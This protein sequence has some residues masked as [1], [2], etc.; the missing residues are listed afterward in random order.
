VYW[1]RNLH[2]GENSLQFYV[3]VSLLKCILCVG[4]GFRVWYKNSSSTLNK[5]FLALCW[6]VAWGAF[7]E[8]HYNF[9]Q[10]PSIA[11]IW[12]QITGSWFV[13]AIIF[14]FTLT[15]VQIRINRVI[16]FVIS[17]GCALFFFILWLFPGFLWASIDHFWWGWQPVPQP[18][19]LFL[20]ARLWVVLLIGGSVAL[21]WKYYRA[22]S[23]EVIK[24]QGKTYLLILGILFPVGFVTDILFPM[25]SVIIPEQGNTLF[26]IGCVSLW[27]LVVRNNLFEVPPEYALIP[28]LS[29][30]SDGFLIVNH[31]QEIIYSNQRMSELLDYSPAEFINKPLSWLFADCTF[32]APELHEELVNLIEIPEEIRNLQL[33][34]PTKFG[35]MKFFSIAKTKLGNVIGPKSNYLFQF[36][37]ISEIIRADHAK[38]EEHDRV[39][40]EY[41]SKFSHELRN[42]L[43][44]IIGFSSLLIDG[45]LGP[46]TDDQRQSIIDIHHSGSYLL[47][48]IN[49]ILE[50]EKIENGGLKFHFEWFSIPDSI[51]EIKNQIVQLNRE[52]QHTIEFDIGESIPP[53]FS[54]KLK[55]QQVIL[56]LLSN[57]IKFTPPHGK[58]N[59]RVAKLENQAIQIAIRD[60]GIGIDPHVHEKIFTKFYRTHPEIEGTGL[61]LAITFQILHHLGSKL[62]FTSIEGQ[63]STFYFILPLRPPDS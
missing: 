55:I 16:K 49:E 35:N 7:T 24:H 38:L 11:R 56:N 2:R 6:A 60:T 30:M 40:Q 27:I 53:V 41:I 23:N 37:D 14:D 19:G 59:I 25:I 29:L 8:F 51:N 46:L 63:G 13:I 3:F 48:I 9:T 43:N 17:Y 57:A 61:G 36:T 39:S 62:E 5:L 21:Q 28:I 22:N 15:F 20:L 10:D 12:I 31:H 52:K 50:Y 33:M 47:Q 34:K 26:T 58:I 45:A 4:I 42:P 1:K 54:S 32:E 18:G 44:S